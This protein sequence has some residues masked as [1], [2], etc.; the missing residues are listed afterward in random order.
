MVVFGQLTNLLGDFDTPPL[1][2]ISATLDN[3]S[4]ATHLVSAPADDTGPSI[5]AATTIAAQPAARV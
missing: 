1:L 5:A 3:G 2:L 4:H